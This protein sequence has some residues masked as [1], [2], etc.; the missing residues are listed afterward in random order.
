ML[1]IWGHDEIPDPRW[2]GEGRS[3]W[4]PDTAG[5]QP[6]V[7]PYGCAACDAVYDFRTELRS[8]RR[9]RIQDLADLAGQLVRTERLGEEVDA[10]S[11]HPLPHQ[12]LVGVAGHE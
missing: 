4:I 12:G 6:P 11:V 8:Q 3:G 9:L 7:T 2:S 10:R 5:R 1:P